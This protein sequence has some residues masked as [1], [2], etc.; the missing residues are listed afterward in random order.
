MSANE[1]DLVMCRGRAAWPHLVRQRVGSIISTGSISG[2]TAL[3]ATPGNFAHA[4]T[5]G[6]VISLTR[7]LA[8]QGGPHGIRANCLSPGIIQSSATAELLSDPERRAAHLDALM[9]R[10]IGTPDDVAGAA[11]FLASDDSAWV[12]GINVMV[13]GGYSAR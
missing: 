13:D 2:V 6:A 5:K 1:V 10:R 7:E 8:L 12:T 11:L 4:A 9:L 3:P